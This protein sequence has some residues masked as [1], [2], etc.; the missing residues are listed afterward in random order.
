VYR[1]KETY[2]QQRQ[3]FNGHLTPLYFLFRIVKI[4]FGL[5]LATRSRKSGPMNAVALKRKTMKTPAGWAL[6][7]FAR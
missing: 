2:P 6:E 7:V 4:V 1:T 3:A 5:L